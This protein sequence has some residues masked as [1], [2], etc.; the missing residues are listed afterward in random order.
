MSHYKPYPANRESGV[1]WIGQ[2]PE[3]WNVKPVKYVVSYN[4]DSLPET[5]ATDM[6]I[7]Y[8]DISIVSHNEVIS[9]SEGMLFG[10]DPS[11]TRRRDKTV[12]IIISTVRTYLKA[13]AA[14]DDEHAYCVYSTGFA[15]L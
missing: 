5:E 8:V 11:R 13:V 3:H 1:E 15:I 9:S 2:V 7:R 6:P 4:D 10:N 12:D 14:V